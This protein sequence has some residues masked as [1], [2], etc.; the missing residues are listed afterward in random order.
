MAAP[1]VEAVLGIIEFRGPFI[2][3]PAMSFIEINYSSRPRRSQIAAILACRRALPQPRQ[4]EG[5]KRESGW[6]DNSRVAVVGV[7]EG[8]GGGPMLSPALLLCYN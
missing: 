1:E 5:R 8:S 3:T 6:P 7:E 4:P 2:P